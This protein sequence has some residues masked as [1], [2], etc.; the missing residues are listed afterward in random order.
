M[1]VLLLAALRTWWVKR[2]LP[3][4]PEG[5]QRFLMPG[6]IGTLERQ[7][8]PV[9]IEKCNLMKTVGL[10]KVI[11]NT[12]RNILAGVAPTGLAGR[13]VACGPPVAYPF[14]GQYN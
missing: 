4:R 11:G 7:R 5:V 10:V 2:H 3:Y 13:N 8:G 6:H 12:F 1:G 14:N 9:T